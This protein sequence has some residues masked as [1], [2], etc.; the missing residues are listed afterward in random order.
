MNEKIL[1]GLKNVRS[2]LTGFT[3]VFTALCIL[4]AAT[5]I[6]KDTVGARMSAGLSSFFFAVVFIARILLGTFIKGYE[7]KE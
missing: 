5:V 4:T 6:E 3:L 1:K 7:E 2:E